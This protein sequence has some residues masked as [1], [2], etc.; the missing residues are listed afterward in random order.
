MEY[1]DF[2]ALTQGPSTT[3]S[4]KPDSLLYKIM[5]FLDSYMSLPQVSDISLYTFQ[6]SVSN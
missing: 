1:L 3:K 6:T 4:V 2:F 5:Q